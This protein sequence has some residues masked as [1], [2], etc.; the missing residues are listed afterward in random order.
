MQTKL[1]EHTVSKIPNPCGLRT[2]CWCKHQLLVI[3]R[4][5]LFLDSTFVVQGT[6]GHNHNKSC[7]VLP[8]IAG[9]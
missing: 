3:L 1:Q 7:N 4:D 9:D 6:C 5:W 2:C 8:E